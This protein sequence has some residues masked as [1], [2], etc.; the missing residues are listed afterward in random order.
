MRVGIYAR[1]STQKQAEKGISIDDQIRR[2][3]DFCNKNSYS[4]EIFKDEGFSGDLPIQNRPALLSLFEKFFLKDKELNGL[5]VVEFDRLTRNPKESITIREILTDNNIQLFELSGPVNLKD[6][7]QDL[8][9]GIKGL[10]GSFERKK[11]IVRIKRTLE[12]SALQGKALGGPIQNY[13]YKKD[14]KKMIVIEPKEAKVVKSIYK[15]CL[16]GNGTKLI[17]AHLNKKGVP[18]KRMNLGGMKMKVKDVEK[19]N[20]IWRDSVIYNILTNPIYKGERHFKEHIISCD[21]I[22]DK[23]VFD[24]VQITL[25]KR[26]HFKNTTNIYFYLLKGL[27]HCAKCKSRFY[28]RKRED[29]SDNQYICSSQRYSEE[30][31]GT[32]GIN[33]KRLDDWIWESVL[34]LPVDFKS[35]LHS[36][37]EDNLIIGRNWAIKKIQ[38]IKE[39][40]EDEAVKLIALFSK[41]KSGNRFTKKRLEE[42]EIE[43]NKCELQILE[44]EKK[45]IK[46]EL[47]EEILLF[48][49]KTIKPLNKFEI[50]D[51]EKQLII[52]A[53]IEK[54]NISWN[55]EELKH[56]IQIIYK[57][58]SYS[59]IL[60]TKDITINYKKSGYSVRVKDFDESI[61][62]E[63]RIPSS[64][65]NTMSNESKDFFIKPTIKK[66]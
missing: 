7:T 20:F 50:S 55:S 29:L 15:L 48:L 57:F 31:C 61:K 43:T 45:N 4:Y 5:F 8:L 44:L 35:A 60:L 46:S 14:E 11:T 37:V 16:E 59:E 49:T 53:L 39:S 36:R 56:Q 25:K 17:A 28:G 30:Y 65:I 62:L 47:E 26:K 3:I 38:N 18:T 32:R 23:N 58:D 24:A 52:R 9:M 64:R 19:S 1:V 13:G 66:K 51:D 40:L 42:I 63:I 22:I 10:L 54:I 21:A 34:S 6:P 33:I 27:L 2:G 12:T 41:N